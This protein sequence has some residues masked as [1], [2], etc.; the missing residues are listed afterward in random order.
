M[1]SPF[2]EEEH[3][4]FLP[5]GE[6]T[7]PPSNPLREYEYVPC[8]WWV[9]H[10]EKGLAFHNIV[11]RQGRRQRPGLG[12]PQCNADERVARMVWPKTYPWPSELVYLEGVWVPVTPQFE[13]QR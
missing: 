1:S 13:E 8:H 10:P 7:T 3:Y 9:V 4:Q 5:I 12:A 11:S 6:A 2:L